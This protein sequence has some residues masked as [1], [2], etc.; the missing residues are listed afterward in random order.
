MVKP[1]LDMCQG[2]NS[3]KYGC[4]FLK[5]ILLFW[6]QADRQTKRKRSSFHWFTS[7]MPSTASTGLLWSTEGKT[8]SRAPT[9][10]QGL[11]HLSR[12]YF[13]PGYTS[14]GSWNWEQSQD[15][16]PNPPTWMKLS[17]GPNQDTTICMQTLKIP[18]NRNRTCIFSQSPQIY[19]NR[20]TK[21]LVN[22]KIHQKR[23]L[24]TFTEWLVVVTWVFK[25]K[26]L[27]SL[28]KKKD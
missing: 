26:F 14:V 18:N 4:G 3:H 24:M 1:R 8:Q 20:M 2:S 15:S 28:K 9:R 11:N 21:I 12:H 25:S 6:R 27:H 22:W 16:S 13:L 17:T 10:W 19:R 7:Q 23:T 5:F